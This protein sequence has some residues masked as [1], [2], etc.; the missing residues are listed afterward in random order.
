[1]IIGR[2]LHS[3]RKLDD[4]P[5]GFVHRIEFDRAIVSIEQ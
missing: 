2:L 1:M 5:R 4:P 3:R